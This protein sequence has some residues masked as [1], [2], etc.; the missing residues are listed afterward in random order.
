VSPPE[1]AHTGAPL[2]L[3]PALLVPKLRIRDAYSPAKLRLAIDICHY[4]ISARSKQSF[5][6]KPVPK[7]ELG[8]QKKKLDL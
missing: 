3:T 5:A 6:K 2:Q 4:I 8:N 1:G 7:R